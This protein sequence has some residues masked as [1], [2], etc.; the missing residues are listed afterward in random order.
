M[1]R[2]IL[3]GLYAVAFACVLLVPGGGDK[4]WGA[5]VNLDQV[6]L[7]AE[8]WLGCHHSSSRT[9]RPLAVEGHRLE[10][11]VGTAENENSGNRAS[12]PID[13]D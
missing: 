9:R 2:K 8:N 11:G 12:G 13:K 1:T 6:R 7:F 4:A 3:R 5:T 10:T